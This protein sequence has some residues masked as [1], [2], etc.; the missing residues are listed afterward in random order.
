MKYII[1]AIPFVLVFSMS[2][3]SVLS[4]L[5]E[6][7]LSEPIAFA[8][9]DHDGNGIISRQEFIE[10][11]NEHIVTTAAQGHSVGYILSF[12]SID[13][14][15]NGQLS[16]SELTIAQQVQMRYRRENSGGFSSM[17]PASRYEQ[18][19]KNTQFL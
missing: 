16:E 1:K 3:I 13:E 9:Y 5:S 17:S 2:V 15:K 7:S 6:F 4:I 18:I 10:V 8:N 12:P 11:T 14:D 19:K